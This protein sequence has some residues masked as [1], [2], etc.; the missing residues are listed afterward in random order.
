MFKKS[1][2]QWKV[3]DMGYHAFSTI[4]VLE[5]LYPTHCPQAIG[6]AKYYVTHIQKKRKV[7]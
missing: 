6:M 1:F 2:T 7:D 3:N 5:S 4:H